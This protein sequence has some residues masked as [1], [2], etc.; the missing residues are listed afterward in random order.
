MSL[1]LVVDDDPGVLDVVSFMLRREGFEVDEQC[2]GTAA[3]AA[4]TE[5]TTSIS[6][7]SSNGLGNNPRCWS[8]PLSSANRPS[9][10]AT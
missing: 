1:I 5:A 8:G 6:S 2:D 10:S 4:V 3:L 7:S 9:A